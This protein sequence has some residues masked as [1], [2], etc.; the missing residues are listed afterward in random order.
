MRR[1]AAIA[2]LLPALLLAGCGQDAE[3]PGAPEATE[4]ASSPTEETPAATTGSQEDRDVLAAIEVSGELGA[5]PTVTF[6]PEIVLTGPAAVVASE[7]EGAELVEGQTIT[8][9]FAVYGGD[10]VTPLGSSWADGA[11]TTIILGDPTYYAELNGVLAGQ[12]I[13][14][15]VILGLPGNVGATAEES[16][17]AT[18][19]VIEVTDANDTPE[20]LE[21]AEGTA[22]EPAAGL[23]VVTLADN[24]EPAIEVP[25]GAVEPTEL[26]VQPLITGDG[27][28]VEAGQ[29]VTFHYSG[30]LWDGTSFDSSWAKG[31]PFTTQIGV[32]SLIDGWDSGLLGQTVG[33]QV[34]LVVPSDLGYGDAGSATIP[35]GATLIFVVDIL[36]AA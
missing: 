17:P 33:S 21:R 1:S 2:L 18:L 7:G 36:A 29:V 34:L 32:G 4:N 27:A 30:W 15:R 14:A 22:V 5:E 20:P 6:T 23:P 19:M 10:A 11:P 13:G 16:Y 24:G 31:T 25:A 9:D 8:L 26:V 28:A 12:R 3:T 35:G